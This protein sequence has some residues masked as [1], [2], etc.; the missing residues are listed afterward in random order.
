MTTRGLRD[1]PFIKRD[2]RK[3]HDGAAWVKPAPLVK[4]RH[5]FELNERI[6][7]QGRVVTA[8]DEAEVEALIA[9]IRA[10][11]EIAAVAVC[12]L[13][14]YLQP[15]HEQRLGALFARLAPGLP[16]SLSSQVPAR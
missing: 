9:R 16:I 3:Y 2:K 14:A 10:M 1:V 11:P 6:D 13:F 5:C 15:A 7:A 12:L 8:L 4:R